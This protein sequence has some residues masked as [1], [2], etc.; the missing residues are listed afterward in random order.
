MLACP[1]PAS[2]GDVVS[3][4]PPVAN[5]NMDPTE[6]D[7]DSDDSSRNTNSGDNDGDEGG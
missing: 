6:T 7:S 1:K 3:I 2:N 5:D 4:N